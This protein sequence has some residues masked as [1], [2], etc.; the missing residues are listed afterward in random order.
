MNDRGK[1]KKNRIRLGPKAAIL[2]WVMIFCLPGLIFPKNSFFPGPLQVLDSL[3]RIFTGGDFLTRSL[4]TASNVL[5]GFFIGSILGVLFGMLSGKSESFENFLKVPLSL[6]K[7]VPVASFIILSLFWFPLR[8]VSIFVVFLI[9]FPVVYGHALS[10]WKSLDPKMVEMARV[11][12]VK[13]VTYFRAIVMDHIKDDLAQGFKTGIGMAWKAGV[14]AEVISMA[15]KSIG[16]A[17]YDSK[18]YLEMADLFAWTLWLVVISAMSERL[19]IILWK[20]L[21]RILSR[22]PENPETPGSPGRLGDHGKSSGFGGPDGLENPD[23]LVDPGKQAGF[24]D[25]GAA[26]G[27]V[28]RGKTAGFGDHGRLDDHGKPGPPG[29]PIMAMEKISLSYSD[30]PVLKDMS[31]ELYAGDRLAITGQSGIGKTSLIRIIAGLEGSYGGKVKW[32]FEGRKD[33]ASKP[34]IS[35]QFQEDRLIENAGLVENLRLVGCS[36]SDIGAA[37]KALD[38]EGF[39]DGPVKGM[40]GGMKRRLSLIRA[41]L[42]PSDLVVLDEPL[43]GMDENTA[44]KAMAWADKEL[45]RRHLACII[46]SHDLDGLKGFNINRHI[47]ILPMGQAGGRARNQAGGRA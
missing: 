47:E 8:G 10:A 30:K 6:I 32:T 45:G 14:A 46:A 19:L 35:M 7:S 16:G 38:L 26:G 2:V 36:D 4:Y 11:F 21:Q 42:K 33:K 24:G 5:S 37:A 20:K 12:V 29:K 44:A 25:P 39:G 31:L 3:G 15:G 9:V 40:S 43:A 22:I 17:I 23:R 18:V 27:Q 34:S 41:V 28:D 1:N 13:P